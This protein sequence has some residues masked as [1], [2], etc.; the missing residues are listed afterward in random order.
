M[1]ET[2]FSLIEKATAS[3]DKILQGWKQRKDWASNTGMAATPPFPC[4]V[5]ALGPWTNSPRRLGIG[6]SERG[7]GTSYHLPS[8]LCGPGEAMGAMQRSAMASVVVR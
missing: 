1:T 7:A 4:G 8:A 2:A 6:L 5:H 3:D